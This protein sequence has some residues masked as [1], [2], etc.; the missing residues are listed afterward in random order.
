MTN[1]PYLPPENQDQL[2]TEAGAVIEISA[3]WVRRI[4]SPVYF[5]VAALTGVS[6]TFM[7][8]A[9]LGLGIHSHWNVLT[10]GAAI[11]CWLIGY[12][13]PL[14]YFRLASEVISQVYRKPLKHNP[15]D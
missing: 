3:K 14:F 11:V 12:F 15:T 4:N 2:P 13:V 9:L 6:I 5:L 1:N 8:L 7:P 10:V